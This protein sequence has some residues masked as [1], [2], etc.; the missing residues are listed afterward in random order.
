LERDIGG[1]DSKPLGIISFAHGEQGLKRVIT[2]DNEASKVCQELSTEV[3]E[4]EKE[5]CCSKAEN[6]IDLGDRGLL[7]EVVQEG[8]LGKLN[9]ESSATLC[10][11][12]DGEINAN[13]EESPVVVWAQMMRN[14]RNRGGSRLPTYLLVKI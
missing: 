6:D 10:R 13:R 7:F 9:T 14:G 1:T 12:H 4:D 3:E 2:R 8:I 5:V 11:M